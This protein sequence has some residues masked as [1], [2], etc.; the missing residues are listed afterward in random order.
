MKDCNNNLHQAVIS[1]S[2]RAS[3]TSLTRMFC[4]HQILIHIV[5]EYNSSGRP[6][7]HPEC[8]PVRLYSCNCPLPTMD[9]II[10]T[11]PC[12]AQDWA[13]TMKAE[14]DIANHHIAIDALASLLDNKAYPSNAAEKITMAYEESIKAPSNPDHSN[15]DVS[16]FYALYLCDAIRTF[17]G[18]SR[19]LVDLLLDISR[20]PVMKRID[21]SSVKHRNGSVYWRDMPSWSYNFLEHGLRQY[22]LG[23]V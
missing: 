17:S 1:S 11:K 20:R 7:S 4:M 3:A 18:A 6:C 13:I 14:T 21:G 2:D 19:R 16:E 8:C 15:N 22:F 10:I 23:S 12:T 5:R 9:H